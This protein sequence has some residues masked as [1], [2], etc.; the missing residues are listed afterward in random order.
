LIEDFDGGSYR[1]VSTVRFRDAVYVLHAFKKKSKSGIKTPQRETDL[2]K[3][4]LETAE[5]D[6]LRRTESEPDK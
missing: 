5:A 3:G 6:H 4:R 2:K 1:A